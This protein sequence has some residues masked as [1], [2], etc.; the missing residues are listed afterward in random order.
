MRVIL[1]IASTLS[2]IHDRQAAH[3]DIKPENLFMYSGSAVIG[4]FGLVSY[5]GKE[6]ITA[7]GERL[8]PIH[9]LAPELIGNADEPLDC[10]PGDVYA[11]RRP[12]GYWRLGRG[13]R[14]PD[15]YRPTRF[16]LG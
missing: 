4:D 14:F 15:I 9:Y 2:D 13:I 12:F 11:W 3:R 10:R 6:P 1:E 16:R 8:G 5:P 7:D